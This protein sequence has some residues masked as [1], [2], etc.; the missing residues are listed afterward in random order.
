MS[1]SLSTLLMTPALAAGRHLNLVFVERTTTDTTNHVGKV[2][3]NPGDIRT[4]SNN[5]F[6]QKDQKQVG[7][8]Q[9]YCIRVHRGELGRICLSCRRG[10]PLLVISPRRHLGRPAWS[11][12]SIDSLDPEAKLVHLAKLP[13]DIRGGNFSRFHDFPHLPLMA[14]VFA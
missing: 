12:R 6:D 9:G 13:N 14:S 1:F 7:S 5:V 4:F 3:D 10:A 8:E 11:L 2:D